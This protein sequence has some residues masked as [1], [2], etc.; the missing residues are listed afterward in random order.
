MRL[1][2][3]S[4]HRSSIY[5]LA[6]LWVVIFHG[7]AID[8]V[9]Y[10]F[11]HQHLLGWLQSIISVGNV[12]VDVFLL[13]S[14]VCL[15]FSFCKKQDAYGFMKKR[16]AR[17]VP[18]VLIIYGVYWLVY[19]IAKGQIAGFIGR[20]TLLQFWFTGDQTIWFVSLIA[21]LYVVYP[22]IFWFLYS[23]G[24][25]N[26][27]IIVLLA[28]TYLVVVATSVLSPEWYKQVEIALT[29]IPSFFVGCWLGQFV[30][31]KKKVSNIVGVIALVVSV[32]FVVVL[33]QGLLHGMERRFFYLI[34]GLSFAYAFALMFE[35]LERNKAIK[36]TLVRFI[37]FVGTF[38]LELYLSHIMLNQVWRLGPWYIEGSFVQ[39]VCIAICALVW[40]YIAMRLS[41]PI[42]ERIKR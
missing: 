42:V 6:I 33:N 40:A 37:A 7:T 38:S 10:T 28:A 5:G 31:Y 32:L 9:D 18:P 14:G 20:V 26:A 1:D 12:G 2:I 21:I 30:Y 29:R 36:D 24:N 11:G 25:S 34:G 4:K 15:Y 17:I 23:K 16:I 39:Y 8:K 22:Y 13:L 41:A 3:V 35:V 27:R 19:C